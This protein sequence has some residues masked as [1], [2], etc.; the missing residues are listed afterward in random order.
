LQTQKS[1]VR[2]TKDGKG[3]SLFAMEDIVQ[4]EYVIEYVGKLITKEGQRIT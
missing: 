4:D 3:S 2:Q 1:K